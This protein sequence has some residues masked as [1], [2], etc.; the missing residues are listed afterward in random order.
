MDKTK[1]ER[2]KYNSYGFTQ[3]GWLVRHKEGFCLGNNTQIGAGTIID[4][5]NKV[6]IEDDVKIGFGVIILS[7]STIGNKKGKV[8]LK[9]GCSIGSN[10]V[11]SPGVTIGNNSTIGCNS[12]VKKNIPDGQFW[13]GNPA[14]KIK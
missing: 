7:H 6:I 1:Q 3:W 8:I 4:A 11:I 14:R 13:A 10:C 5:M 12:F 9:K 2:P